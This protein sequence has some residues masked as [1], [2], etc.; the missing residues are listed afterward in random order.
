MVVTEAREVGDE[1]SG[2]ASSFLEV[3]M[4]ERCGQEDE[5]GAG[6]LHGCWT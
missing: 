1:V 5:S 2:R 6:F 3:M 4:G